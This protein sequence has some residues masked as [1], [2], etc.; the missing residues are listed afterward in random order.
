MNYAFNNKCSNIIR[1]VKKLMKQY[2]IT[3]NNEEQ[4]KVISKKI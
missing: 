4:P 1:V 2:D 3:N